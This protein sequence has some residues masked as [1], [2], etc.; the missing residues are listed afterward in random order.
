MIGQANVSRGRWS[1]F[2][3]LAAIVLAATAISAFAGGFSLETIRR[4]ARL[5]AQMSLILFCAAFGAGAL[6][7]LRPSLVSRALRRNR[8]QI[9]LAFAVSHGVHAAALVAFVRMDP[10]LFQAL[11]G[12]PTFIFGGLA[13]L[14]IV[15]MAATSF[16]R[17]A[18]LIGPRVWRFVHLIGGWLIWLIFLISEGKRAIHAPGYW[19]YVLV[20]LLVFGLRLTA[21]QGRSLRRTPATAA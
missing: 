5:S 7:G 14:F 12:P 6:A 18:A 15:A 3:G 11:T 20:L 16:D 9:G 1:V 2:F 10:R 19:P 8:R 17:T 21:A 4:T 13:Y